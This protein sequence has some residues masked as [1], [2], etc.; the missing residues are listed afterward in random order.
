MLEIAANVTIADDELVERFVRATG[1]GGPNVNKV[2]TPVELRFEAVGSNATLEVFLIE[3]KRNRDVAVA[4]EHERR[5][6]QRQGLERDLFR[7]DI[8]PD[9]IAWAP[10]EELDALDLGAGPEAFEKLT[11]LL[12]QL[13]RRPN[14]GRG[15][16]GVELLDVDPSRAQRDE[17][18]VADQ[19]ETRPLSHERAA[20]IRAGAVADG[21][22]E[23]PN[24]IRRL[25]AD[26]A[27]DRLERVKVRVDVRDDRDS[28]VE[29][30]GDR[31]GGRPLGGRGGVALAHIGSG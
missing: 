15:R 31:R 2:S 27:Q 3:D 20:L 8:V 12:R 26:L 18:V 7:E 24:R 10:V 13:L 25:A 6:G 11:R 1:P 28:H 23:A 30:L 16:L 22:A 21:V 29:I 5:M 19:N 9:W 14:R 4:D 17:I